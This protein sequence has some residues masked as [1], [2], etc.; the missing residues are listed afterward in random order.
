MIW[1]QASVTFL[2]EFF[3]GIIICLFDMFHAPNI[4]FGKF[5]FMYFGVL[6]SAGKYLS[7]L[8]R[9]RGCFSQL[10]S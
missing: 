2:G 5:W 4:L 3:N 6:L 1:F 8:W 7:I 9:N 10:S